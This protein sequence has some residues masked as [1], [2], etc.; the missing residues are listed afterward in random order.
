MRLLV[1]HAHPARDSFN[2]ALSRAVQAG[3][4]QGGHDVRLIDLYGEGF[5]P[6]MSA[7]E[8]R[9]DATSTA[10]DPVLSA[11]ASHLRWAEGVVLVYPTWWQ[12]PPA[13]L[14]GWIDR[15][16]RPGVAFV[17]DGPGGRLRPLLTEMRLVAVVTTLG[18]P[19]WL[20]AMAM[21]IAGRRTVLA[22]LAACAAPGARRL[23]MALHAMD[24]SDAARRDSFLGRVRDRFRTIGH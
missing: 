1:V 14:K 18:A 13:I 15:V 19:G 23:W 11:H 16:W 10:P 2:A 8:W 24:T 12:G 3:A 17:P 20:A 9:N 21:N 4:E 22:G 5:D 7:T 6:V